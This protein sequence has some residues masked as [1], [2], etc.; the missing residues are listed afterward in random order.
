MKITRAALVQKIAESKG[1]ISCQVLS[2][3]DAKALK[4]GKKGTYNEHGEQVFEKIPNTFGTIMKRSAASVSIGTDYENAVNRV[5]EKEGN[6]AAGEF[7][8]ASIWGGK[9]EHLVPNKIIRHVD[10]GTLYLY[11]QSSDKQLDAFSPHVEFETVTGEKLS[12]D[13]VAPFLPVKAPSVKQADFGN[14]NERH[15]RMIAL[16]NVLAIKMMGE[17]YELEA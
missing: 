16:D 12:R 2:L 10:K 17:V 14:E 11:C 3:T 9:G 4:N 5:A 6:V 7:I 15:V 1:N 13:E 8:A